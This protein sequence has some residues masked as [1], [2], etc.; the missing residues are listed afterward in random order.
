MEDYI[1]VCI[2]TNKLIE[3]SFGPRV[4]EILKENFSKISTIKVLGTM[5]KPIHFQN[6]PIYRDYLKQKQDKLIIIDSALGN[7]KN[8][9]ETYINWGGIE[10]GKAYDK[11]FYFPAHFNIKTVVGTKD[12]T[13]KIVMNSVQRIERI[14]YINELAQNLAWKITNNFPTSLYKNLKNVKN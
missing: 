7:L 14:S 4:G 12:S 6:A 10:I 5:Q 1:F 11:S 8:L 9:G 3:D 2:G 13:D